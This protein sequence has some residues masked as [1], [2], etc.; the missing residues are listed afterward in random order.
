MHPN[1]R[2]GILF[3]IVAQCL[4]GRPDQLFVCAAFRKYYLGILRRLCILCLWTLDFRRTEE[5][6]DIK[7][8]YVHVKQS[9]G[10]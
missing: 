4:R 3:R 8:E 7:V 6:R 5:P 2:F 9:I 10:Q 1:K